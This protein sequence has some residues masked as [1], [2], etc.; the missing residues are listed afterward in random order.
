MLIGYPVCKEKKEV[1]R[2]KRNKET[3]LKGRNEEQ[4][5]KK[6]YKRKKLIY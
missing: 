4:N 1:S 3:G 6:K 5:T 2:R